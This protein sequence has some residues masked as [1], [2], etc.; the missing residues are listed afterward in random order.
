MKA[1]CQRVALVAGLLFSLAVARG[2]YAATGPDTVGS[3]SG[4]FQVKVV[5]TPPPFRTLSPNGDTNVLQLKPA[6]LAVSAERFKGSLWEQLGIAPNAD[7]SGKI[8]IDVYPARSL[9]DEET[10]ISTPFL[11]HWNYRVDLPDLLWKTRYARA[12]SGV[13]LLE[14]AN[15]RAAPNG[16]SAEVP[17]W[18]VDGL[19]QQVLAVDGEKILLAIPK[20]KGDRP[21]ASRLNRSESSFD[22]LADARRI[23]QNTP[24]LTFD[25]LSWPS[26]EQ[27]TGQDGGV[28][29]ASAQL[30]VAQLLELKNG[31]EKMRN[32]IADMPAYLNW[33]IA[34]FQAFGADLK[35]PID[36]EKWWALRV[37]DFAARGPGPRWTTEVSL[38]RLQELLSVPV[39]FRNASN[40][41]PLYTDISLQLALQNLSAQQR[42]DIIRTKARDL[43]L[44]EL[45]LAPPFGE[46]ADGYRRTLIDFLGE[47]VSVARPSAANK[48]GVPVSRSATVAETIKNLDA[49]DARRRA[50]EANVE[51]AVR[52]RSRQGSQ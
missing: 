46:L 12:M 16:H 5:G 23:L 8:F 30:F 11:N 37:L 51:I 44:V 48:H 7:W 10:I 43:A 41:L 38:N 18:L 19:A 24:A 26:A 6:L 15:R 39:E 25:Q 14:L 40:S 27:M 4:Q 45:R 50:A 22:P 28:Y 20:Q 47:M 31:R 21:I 49:L 42:D 33:Q 35:R 13:V 32:F 17:A 1:V 52:A 2:Q 9:D 29:Y 34:F 3:V 36:V